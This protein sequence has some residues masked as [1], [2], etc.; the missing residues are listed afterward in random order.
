MG[1]AGRVEEEREEKQE[2]GRGK[3]R[4]KWRKT[5][6][7]EKRKRRKGMR[8]RKE[9]GGLIL[10]LWK[11]RQ[12]E[13]L[14][15]KRH[16]LRT[17]ERAR[18][19]KTVENYERLTSQSSGQGFWFLGSVSVSIS[20][21]FVHKI[22]D[23]SEI[24]PVLLINLVIDMEG[25]GLTL[26]QE[27]R[28]ALSALPSFH[29]FSCFG[30]AVFVLRSCRQDKLLQNCAHR[31]PSSQR[32]AASRVITLNVKVQNW[33][34]F[35]LLLIT[36]LCFDHITG[37][38]RL[39]SKL[40]Q[41]CFYFLLAGFF[42]SLP[43][44]IFHLSCFFCLPNSTLR[45]TRDSSTCA[46][47]SSPSSESSCFGIYFCFP[48][49]EPSFRFAFWTSSYSFRNFSFCLQPSKISKSTKKQSPDR[50]AQSSSTSLSSQS[51]SSSES[52]LRSASAS[53]S[54]SSSD[55]L[56]TCSP[57][58]SVPLLPLMSQADILPSPPSFPQCLASCFYSDYH[59]PPPFRKLRG[60]SSHI[61]FLGCF[62]FL[63]CF[64]LLFMC[65]PFFFA[66]CCCSRALIIR[67][68]ILKG[69]HFLF[70]HWVLLSCL[71][72]LS[73]VLSVLLHCLPL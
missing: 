26:K 73:L 23:S 54:I 14:R 9:R 47:V 65:S 43:S 2:T 15:G 38:K 33:K 60:R 20:F 70:M 49:G 61:A 67:A 68:S 3:K 10:S 7:H 11:N 45:W 31:C 58:S 64:I 50:K 46:K 52:A 56:L 41:V 40:Y 30:C 59:P 36:S 53:S 13:R 37:R 22:M 4:S 34:N 8:K 16:S 12:E 1:K 39:L 51:S 6:R 62:F 66:F 25:K 32:H 18:D 29:C 71:F 35:G 5:K 55:S 72:S 57:S 19:L 48:Q 27:V 42:V 24:D 63:L 17:R 44:S 21:R 69:F 28:P